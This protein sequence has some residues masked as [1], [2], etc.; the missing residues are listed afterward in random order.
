MN[1]KQCPKMALGGSH[2]KDNNEGRWS[3]LSRVSPTWA[4]RGSAKS[5][6][7]HVTKQFPFW[8]RSQLLNE[9]A[10]PS[11]HPTLLCVWQS[12]PPLYQQP[13]DPQ[14]PSSSWAIEGLV[15]DVVMTVRYVLGSLL[16]LFRSPHPLTSPLFP[17]VVFFGACVNILQF[18]P[19]RKWTNSPS[20]P[21][22][23][24]VWTSPSPPP[25]PQQ[26]SQPA[27][28]VLWVLVGKGGV[29]QCGIM[30][31]SWWWTGRKAGRCWRRRAMRFINSLCYEGE[32][33]AG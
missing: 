3:S 5:Q 12:I 10:R 30:L 6:L 2:A 14:V 22:N 26:K 9:E 23:S 1:S 27:A 11:S 20:T 24:S 32:Y 7:G 29:S 13:S 25:S 31:V 33:D 15:R 18:P 4:S 16:P 17:F 28:D 8:F 19:T 21:S